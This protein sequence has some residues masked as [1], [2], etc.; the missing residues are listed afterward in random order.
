M[1]AVYLYIIWYTYTSIFCVNL[2]YC[3]LIVL[4]NDEVGHYE[5]PNSSFRVGC[6]VSSW[7]LSLSLPLCLSIDT[8]WWRWHLSCWILIF[9]AG[10][11]QK[12]SGFPK[13]IPFSK[14]NWLFGGTQKWMEH[15]VLLQMVVWI[16]MADV[17][18]WNR[19][20]L[21]VEDTSC[22]VTNIGGRKW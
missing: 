9:E 14:R 17:I 11:L 18:W 19:D 10:C 2:N 22:L 8:C 13:N 12:F 15:P 5:N 16:Q 4:T 6:V 3:Y 7:R 1:F 20:V 21:L